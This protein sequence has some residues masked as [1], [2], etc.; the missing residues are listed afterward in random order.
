MT[1]RR[2]VR[3]ITMD[4]VLLAAREQPPPPPPPPPPLSSSVTVKFLVTEVKP[5]ALAVSVTTWSPSFRESLTAE[6]VNVAVSCAVGIITLVGT[7]ASEGSLVCKL[8]V[9]GVAVLEL[10]YMLADKLPPPSDISLLLSTNSSSSGPFPITSKTYG[11]DPEELLAI[12]TVSDCIPLD[13]GA[14]VRTNVV[15]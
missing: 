11:S 6:T 9:K 1:V 12:E 13:E 8:T 10:R 15:L 4:D 2:T 7:L 3:Q 5:V 14:N